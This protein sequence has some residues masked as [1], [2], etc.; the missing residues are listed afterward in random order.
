MSLYAHRAPIANP[1]FDY[2]QYPSSPRTP[3]DQLLISWARPSDVPS[4][5]QTTSLFALG[6]PRHPSITPI[7][8]S[9][10]QPTNGGTIYR[11][12]LPTSPSR[13]VRPAADMVALRLL[14]SPL[15]PNIGY[16]VAQPFFSKLPIGRGTP[17]YPATEP[18]L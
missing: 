11:L 18:S 9:F 14:A 12:C 2:Y 4:C 17:C 7:P 5:P 13:L 6:L 15:P 1:P 3:H 16:T 8:N 10:V